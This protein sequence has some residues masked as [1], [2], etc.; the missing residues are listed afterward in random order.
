MSKPSLFKRLRIGQPKTDIDENFEKQVKIIKGS[1]EEGSFTTAA[2]LRKSAM[3]TKPGDAIDTLLRHAVTP[4]LK[5]QGFSKKGR[6]Y[7]RQSSDKGWTELINVQSSQWNS[8]AEAS[9]TINLGLFHAKAFASVYGTEPKT[10]HDYDC[11]I[12]ERIGFIK[13]N[14]EIHK[15]GGKDR[16]WNFDA[17]SDL[18]KLERNIV[19]TVEGKTLRFFALQAAPEAKLAILRQDKNGMIT[20]LQKAAAA[21]YMGD[22]VFAKELLDKGASMKGGYN[23][24]HWRKAYELGQRLGISCQKPKDRPLTI[25]LTFPAGLSR[26]HKNQLSDKMF[27]R[28]TKHLGDRKAG[29]YL[30]ES[31]AT[32]MHYNATLCG[33][34]LDKLEAL[35]QPAVRY[36]RSKSYMLELH[37]TSLTVD[38]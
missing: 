14:G 28:L 18:H 22:R 25:K 30:Y 19:Q 1:I 27:V 32:E 13:E 37:T 36:A 21:Y 34:D 33:P 11:V 12:S 35:I 7:F 15:L 20:W 31:L 26:K 2:P 29:Y 17:R 23:Q 6:T 4:L 10:P 5:A 38:Q 3:A 9:F 24:W 8:S 16:W